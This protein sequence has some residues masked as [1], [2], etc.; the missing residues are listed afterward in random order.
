[1]YCA[2]ESIS[3]KFYILYR[4]L[5]Y[6]I[7]LKYIIYSVSLRVPGSYS[8]PW[9]HQ[10]EG[11]KRTSKGGILSNHYYNGQDLLYDFT[12]V[13]IDIYHIVLISLFPTP[14]DHFHF[15]VISSPTWLLS[16]QCA[17][18]RSRLGWMR[19]RWKTPRQFLLI[20]I[21]WIISTNK[22]TC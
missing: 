12:L 15:P 3:S 8:P 22:L 9:R 6:C 11:F 5:C 21:R 17:I 16:C 14:F 13:L 1:M 18:N 19:R 4:V 2:I 7:Y 10:R 20:S